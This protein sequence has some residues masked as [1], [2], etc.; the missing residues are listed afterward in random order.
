MITSNRREWA[1]PARP[2]MEEKTR[3]PLGSSTGKRLAGQGII[4]PVDRNDWS[5]A[6]GVADAAR[7]AQQR[8]S[9]LQAAEEAEAERQKRASKSKTGVGIEDWRFEQEEIVRIDKEIKEFLESSMDMME[10]QSFG[11]SSS[12]SGCGTAAK[13]ASTWAA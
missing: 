11:R 9:R 10:H 1:C 12:R 13:A 3:L 4:D 2:P 5:W 7:R 8:R 6:P